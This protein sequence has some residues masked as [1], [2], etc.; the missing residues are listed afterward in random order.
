[1]QQEREKREEG[2]EEGGRKGNNGLKN[3]WEQGILRDLEEKRGGKERENRREGRQEFSS[4]RKNA[5]YVH[6]PLQLPL[7]PLLFVPRVPREASAPRDDLEWAK[8]RIFVGAFFTVR[9]S[10][11][12]DD[13]RRER[14]TCMHAARRTMKLHSSWRIVER[15][16]GE[17]KERF[18]G[19]GRRN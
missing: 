12:L 19:E 16:R 7:P 14:G 18:A 8:F 11:P 9:L 5:H 13:R 17:L 10:Y 15:F 6:A 4:S 1:M 2:R 3:G